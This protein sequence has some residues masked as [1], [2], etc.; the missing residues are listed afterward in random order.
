MNEHLDEGG[1]IMQ[2]PIP[3][4]AQDSRIELE[5]KLIAIATTQL[6]QSIQMLEHQALITKPQLHAHSTYTR[7]I[8]R[9]DGFIE[10]EVL[11][12]GLEG[13]SI[14]SN[15]LPGIITW[16]NN[17]NHQT[18][19]PSQDAHLVIH[20]MV[21]SLSPWP[22]V[23]TQVSIKGIS[24][25]LKILETKLLESHLEIVKLQL[26][27]KPPVDYKTFIAAYNIFNG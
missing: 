17:T 9:R 3:I 19:A 20:R 7:K 26:E 1:I 15:K 8:T 14:P 22:G 13:K 25:R 27:G 16:F 6:K 18:P 5:H 11:K 12:L 4:Y 2:E 23:W 10:L 21:Q 24:T